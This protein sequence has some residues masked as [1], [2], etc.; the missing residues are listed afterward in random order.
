MTRVSLMGMEVDRIDEREAIET[1]IEASG[2]D[3]GGVVMTPNLEH[4][5]S[6]RTSRDVRE[7]F[8]DAELV[9]ADGMPL[10]WASRLQR[11]PLPERVAGSDLIWSLSEAAAARGRSVFL[12]GGNPGA[13]ERAADVLQERAPGLDVA[14]VACPQIGGGP[15][16]DLQAAAARPE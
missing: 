16:A 1:I 2:R 6:Y 9:V 13:A 11:T 12:L 15:E 14:G 3:R 7:A 8:D 5:S 4:L 10:I